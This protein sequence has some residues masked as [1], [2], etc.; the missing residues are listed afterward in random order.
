MLESVSTESLRTEVFRLASQLQ[1]SEFL[2]GEGFD[3]RS[4]DEMLELLAS[5][6]VSGGHDDLCDGPFRPKPQLRKAGHRTRFSDGSFPVFYA[7]L[8]P[9]T[10]ETEAKYWFLK[11][12]TLCQVHDPTRTGRGLGPGRGRHRPLDGPGPKGYH[13]Q[14]PMGQTH[15]KSHLAKPT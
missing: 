4:V 6:D 12:V 15:R 2:R 14:V 8:E 1:D 11:N 5:R 7:S 9:E 3:D 13:G 10:A